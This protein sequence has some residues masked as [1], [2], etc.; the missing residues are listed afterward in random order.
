MQ[1]FLLPNHIDSDSGSASQ[2]GFSFRK[3]SSSALALGNDRSALNPGDT[4]GFG[5]GIATSQKG[6]LFG[7]S[8]QPNAESIPLTSD[9][10]F[11]AQNHWTPSSFKMADSQCEAES[12]S[13]D[14]DR[15]SPLSP[16]IAILSED[17]VS[18]PSALVRRRGCIF[19]TN[20]TSN[21]RT[22]DVTAKLVG[23]SFNLIAPARLVVEKTSSRKTDEEL[24]VKLFLTFMS[25][26]QNLH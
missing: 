17:F 11:S 8:F 18:I 12:W 6:G 19:H 2:I 1:G 15:S 4:L 20:L 9:V 13:E 26:P 21:T 25:L 5:L 7:R 16:E 24:T 14:D 3:Q 10:L 22:V 23:N